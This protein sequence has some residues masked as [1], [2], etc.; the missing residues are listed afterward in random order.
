M[1]NAVLFVGYSTNMGLTYHL[2]H[3][4][5]ALREAAEGR[6]PRIILA[7][8]PGEQNVGLWEKVRSGFPEADICV[9]SKD[10]EPVTKVAEEILKD[11]DSLVIH[12]QGFHQ[13]KS[14]LPAKLAHPNRVKIVATMH[15]FKLGSWKRYPTSYVISKS[16]R[17]H[18]DFTIF[19]CPFAVD[20]FV[21]SGSLFRQGRAGIIP[22]GVEA[23]P[24]EKLNPP[25]CPVGEPDLREL[26]TEEGA[27]RF[28][29]L[30]NFHRPKGHRWLA[31]GM[32]PV[33]KKHT[34]GRLLLLG[35]GSMLAKTKRLV[36][37]LGVA[38]QVFFPGRIDRNHVPW[39]LTRCHVGIVA[40]KTETFG[41]N[42]AEPM[43]AGLPVLGTRIG[44]GRWLIQD[45]ITGMGMRWGDR[46]AL[47]KAA[48]FLIENPDAAK[49]MGCNAQALVRP[50]FTWPKVANAYLR[51]YKS[52]M[53]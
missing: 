16:Y 37:E 50:H 15:S 34:H 2:A 36:Q 19:L 47:C 13:F 12:V 26:L 11:H 22:L 1:K 8:T 49:E 41:H 53:K 43:V 31:E 39:V 7:S 10:F 20:R 32:A 17:R 44:V 35:E 29:Y 40:T 3:L 9:F 52:L 42:Y 14:A 24:A 6:E 23:W 27:F 48:E 38:E 4:A 5:V 21:G 51:L 25:E 18:T 45:Y 30:A 46:K 33:L 28:V